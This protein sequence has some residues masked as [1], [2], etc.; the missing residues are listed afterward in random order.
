MVRTKKPKRC[1][2]DSRIQ[3]GL[4]KNHRKRK[5]NVGEKAGNHKEK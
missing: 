2:R 4:T 1:I 5:N 3:V